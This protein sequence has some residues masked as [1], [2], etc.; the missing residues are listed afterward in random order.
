MVTRSIPV[1]FACVVLL[2]AACQPVGGSRPAAAPSAKPSSLAA[3][4][5]TA[6]RPVSQPVQAA[7]P[8]PSATPRV[9]QGPSLSAAYA[10]SLQ[11]DAQHLLAADGARVVN[12]A[13]S[14]TGCRTA[15]LQVTSSANAL[16]KDLD[17]NPPPECLKNADATLRSAISLYLQGAQIGVK[18]IDDG[19]SSELTQ[20]KGLLDLGTT[21]FRAASTQLGQ[22]ACSVPPPAVAP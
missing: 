9:S 12:C 20:G 16:Q 2:G 1:A 5:Q 15:L 13:S 10:N 7:T 19:S 22:S 11:I 17:A 6:D 14:T 8:R 21:R 4:A 3:R 18:A